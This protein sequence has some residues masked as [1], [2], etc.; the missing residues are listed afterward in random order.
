[1]AAVVSLGSV[2]VDHVAYVESSIV[3]GLTDEYEWFP[4]PGETVSIP[5]VPAEFEQHVDEVFI[6]GKGANQAVAAS[7]AGVGTALLG[8]VGADHGEYEVLNSLDGY[9]VD[10]TGVEV[11]D[12]PTGSAHVFVR[13]D[14]ENHIA[15]TAGANGAVDPAYVR[16]HR[17]TALGASCLLVQNELP[18]PALEAALAILD[19]SDDRPTL[20]S[21]PP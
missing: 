9:G 14:G 12:V 8:M 6:G 11:A 4:G 13:P 7:R 19:E 3:A 15:I 18:K 17:G 10:V 1:M 5:T 21:S 20:T 16:R 2:N